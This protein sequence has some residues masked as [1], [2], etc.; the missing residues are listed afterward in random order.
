MG[1]QWHQLDHM[2][3]ICTSL[4]TDNHTSV[5]SLNF[6]TGRMLF[7]MPNQQY[8]STESVKLKQA[9]TAIVATARNTMSTDRESYLE[10]G[11]ICTPY[12]TWYLRPMRVWPHTRHLHQISY[13]EHL[14][15]VTNS[16]TDKK[17]YIKNWI[18]HIWHHLQC[19]QRGLITD[20]QTHTT[21][22]TSHWKQQVYKLHHTT[23][24]YYYI[25]L[26]AFFPGQSG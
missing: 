16:K 11:A 13:F 6:F 20:L 8:Q 10:G 2:Q 21:S 1:W 18:A 9:S 12:N 23:L 19:L 26:T 3:F 4:Q 17:T 7:L 15:H 25:R 14:H 22:A 5:S 24:H